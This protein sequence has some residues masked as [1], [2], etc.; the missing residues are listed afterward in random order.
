MYPPH[1]LD[2]RSTDREQ[3]Q[4][5]C[6]DGDDLWFYWCARVAGTLYK[7]VGGKMRLVM[8]PG[9]QKSS[10][11]ESNEAGGNDRMI[12]ALEAEFAPKA[13]PRA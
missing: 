3:F 11:W 12:A 13:R 8:W 4:R 2:R 9:S 5:L 1:S 10:L 7:K 6:P